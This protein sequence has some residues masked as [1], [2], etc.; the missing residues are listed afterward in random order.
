[1]GI[2]A[3]RQYL[4]DPS[5]AAG[6]LR[7]LGIVDVRRAHGNLLGMARAGGDGGEY[8]EKHRRRWLRVQRTEN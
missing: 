3:L 8:R 7:G 5:L 2:P 1:M 4:D 6:W